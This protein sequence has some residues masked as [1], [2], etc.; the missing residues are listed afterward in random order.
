MH[1]LSSGAYENFSAYR[2]EE[3][4]R[5]L[6]RAQESTEVQERME[7]CQAL[8]RM[9]LSDW[10]VIP[11]YFTAKPYLVSGEL[12]E[13]KFSPQGYPLFTTARWK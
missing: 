8:E 4:D 13:L 1:L 3:Y 12:Q 7:I 11:V 9:A 10:P 6:R 5:W 2:N